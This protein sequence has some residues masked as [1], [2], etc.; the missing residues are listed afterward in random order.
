MDHLLSSAG[1]RLRYL[2]DR[3][4][5][6]AVDVPQMLEDLAETE[7]RYAMSWWFAATRFDEFDHVVTAVDEATGRYVALLVANDGA[8]AQETFLDLQAAFVIRAMRGSMLMRRM[9]AYAISRISLLSSLPRVIAARTS[10]PICYHTLAM[11]AQ[12]MPGAVIFPNPD[13]AV[14]DLARAGLARRI[15]RRVAPT[16]AYDASTGVI[17][18]AK[19]SGPTCFSRLAQPRTAVERMF[20]SHLGAS[21]QMLVVVDLN[22]ADREAITGQAEKLVRKRWKQPHAVAATP[23]AQ[24]LSASGPEIPTLTA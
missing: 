7:T 10:Q 3:S 12:A 14:V 23:V 1:I 4:L 13:P 9:L 5:L 21:D 18:G 24:A 15:A 8:T 19:L 2:C 17:R 11:F 16:H 22:A 6:N 20:E